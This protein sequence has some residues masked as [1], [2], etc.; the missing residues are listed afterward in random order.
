MFVVELGMFILGLE[1][2]LVFILA[3][4][5]FPCPAYSRC[6]RSVTIRVYI[7]ICS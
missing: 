1:H 3:S 7:G 2:F 6:D 5:L 4:T